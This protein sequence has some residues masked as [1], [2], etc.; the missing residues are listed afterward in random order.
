MAAEPFLVTS[1]IATLF[2][3]GAVRPAAW[4]DVELGVGLD[5]ALLDQHFDVDT[6]GDRT[7]VISP[8]RARPYAFVGVGMPFGEGPSR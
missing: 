7:P 3:S 6:A 4:F 5:L 8:W 1:P 2:V